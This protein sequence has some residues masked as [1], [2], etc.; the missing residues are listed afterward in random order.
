VR[1][2]RSGHFVADHPIREAR[3]LWFSKLR[4]EHGKFP[5]VGTGA[6]AVGGKICG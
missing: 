2:G 6:A 5:A 1:G 3:R 4:G